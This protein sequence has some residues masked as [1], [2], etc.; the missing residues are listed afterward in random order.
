VTL[1]AASRK[2]LDSTDAHRAEL[3][4]LGRVAETLSERAEA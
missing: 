4:N 3:A 2:S 1:L